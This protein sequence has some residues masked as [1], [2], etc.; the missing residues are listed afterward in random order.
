MNC[1]CRWLSVSYISGI[2][3]ITI[4]MKKVRI[5]LILV[6]L[7]I[8]FF[9]V[10]LLGELFSFINY[11]SWLNHGFM[12]MVHGLFHVKFERKK[13]RLCWC[14]R[15]STEVYHEI[16]RVIASLDSDVHE[17]TNPVIHWY[18][19]LFLNF[20]Q[21]LFNERWIHEECIFKG[22]IHWK[23][24]LLDFYL[25]FCFRSPIFFNNIFYDVICLFN[26]DAVFTFN[27]VNI[28]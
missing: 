3:Y 9:E 22:F 20:F 10:T 12:C 25:I 11:L 8:S 28:E 24:W 27:N 15:M 6:Y 13:R 19:M 21:F 4:C 2:I 7:C 23:W 14:I 18:S 16:L 1:W 5:F 26:T 17:S